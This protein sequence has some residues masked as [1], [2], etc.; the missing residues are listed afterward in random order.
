MLTIQE[1]EEWSGRV[2][3]RFQELEYQP[4]EYNQTRV[5]YYFFMSKIEPEI[6]GDRN[7]EFDFRLYA[8]IIKQRNGQHEIQ[9]NVYLGSF[10]PTTV[11]NL[12]RPLNLK[13]KYFDEVSSLVYMLVTEEYKRLINY[14][15]GVEENEDWNI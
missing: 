1:K 4:R 15:Q 7:Q 2:T 14:H 9:T 3:K 6:L 5:K 12:E 13:S 8:N 11:I 10:F